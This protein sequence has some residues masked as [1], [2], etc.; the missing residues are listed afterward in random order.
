MVLGWRI[1][2][3]R[4]QCEHEDDRQFL[5]QFHLDAHDHRDRKDENDNVGDYVRKLSAL[6]ASSFS[7]SEWSFD[8]KS[9]GHTYQQS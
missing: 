3:R 2:L 7:T 5:L 6:S 4:A 9:F 8:M 1:N